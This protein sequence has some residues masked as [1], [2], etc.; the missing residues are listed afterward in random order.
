MQQGPPRARLWHA[1]HA[2]CASAPPPLPPLPLPLLP[3][4]PPRAK[5]VRMA[6]VRAVVYAARGITMP[7]CLGL[8]LQ[9]M[10]QASLL[11]SDVAI[12]NDM[13]HLCRRIMQE[14]HCGLCYK[15]SAQDI[16]R[17]KAL[18]KLRQ[19]FRVQSEM[20]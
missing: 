10:L 18:R 3:P 1:L 19:K 15:C 2:R 14:R 16:T 5:L 13:G 8:I 4:P 12:K 6:R 9:H 11:H 20:R 7:P 17:S